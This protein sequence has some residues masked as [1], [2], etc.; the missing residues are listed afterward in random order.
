MGKGIEM[1]YG[2]KIHKFRIVISNC[3]CRKSDGY[4]EYCYAHKFK[5]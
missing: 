2:L 5:F 3:M 1:S 4:D